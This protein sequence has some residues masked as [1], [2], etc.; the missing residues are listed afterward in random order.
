MACEEEEGEEAVPCT[1]I[2]CRSDD[3]DSISMVWYLNIVVW[4]N[5]HGSSTVASDMTW[6]G[7]VL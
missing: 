5:I 2:G 6:R 7:N 4:R 3:G 1:F